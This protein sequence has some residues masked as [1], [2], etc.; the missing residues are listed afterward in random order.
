M[1]SEVDNLS[2]SNAE[3]EKNKKAKR[4][5]VTTPEMIKVFLGGKLLSK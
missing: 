2:P 1:D 5:I 3:G 4:W